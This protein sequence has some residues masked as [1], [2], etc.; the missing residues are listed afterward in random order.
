VRLRIRA[1]PV[2]Q[3][4]DPEALFA[5]IQRGYHARRKTLANNLK[6]LPGLNAERLTACLQDLG[7]PANVRA[8]RLSLDDWARIVEL[9]R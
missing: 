1:E 8:E 6:G 9:F 7:H 3:V 2:V 5:L 4:D